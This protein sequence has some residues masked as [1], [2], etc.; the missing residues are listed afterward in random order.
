MS[1]RER[2]RFY[3]RYNPPPAVRLGCPPGSSVTKQQ[4][5]DECDINALMARYK[6][7]QL[8]DIAA[9][10]LSVSAV[11]PPRTPMYGDFTQVSDYQE[12]QNIVIRAANDFAAL[13]AAVRDR[14]KNSPAA[15]LTF[16]AGKDAGAVFEELGLL[17]PEAVKR[18]RDERE[19]KKKADDAAAAALAAPPK[20]TK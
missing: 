2:F 18:R 9:K 16:A 17:S 3:S 19:A 14:F 15:F 4:F 5:R 11:A 6:A 1:E 10:P 7:G 12:A 13:P 8:D 20:K